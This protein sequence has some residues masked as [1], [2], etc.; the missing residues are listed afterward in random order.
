MQTNEDS[1]VMTV[2][3]RLKVGNRDEV[4]ARFATS[5]T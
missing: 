5:E 4:L 2:D 1:K 3:R